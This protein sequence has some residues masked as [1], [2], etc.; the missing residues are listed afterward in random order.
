MSA[1]FKE[2]KLGWQ[3]QMYTVKPTMELLNKIEQDVSLSSVAYRIAKG[4][5]PLSQ[6]ATI[7]AGFLRHAGAKVTSEDVYVQ[8]MGGDEKEVSEMAETLMMA[9]FPQLG[10]AEA[11]ATETPTQKPA[12]KKKATKK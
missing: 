3:G 12:R 10:K 8:I 2:L 9:A 11:P 7:I 5:P 6:L 4:D 1:V